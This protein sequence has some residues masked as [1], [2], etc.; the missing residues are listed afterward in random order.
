MA[1]QKRGAAVQVG[2]R[3]QRL[4]IEFGAGPA[5]EV[6]VHQGHLNAPA[7]EVHGGG[8][9]QVTVTPQDQDTHAAILVSATEG[10]RSSGKSRWLQRK[11]F[12]S[13]LLM[14]SSWEELYGWA[15]GCPVAA[16]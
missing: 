5:P 3:D 13:A 6:I 12:I 7:G 14:A 11:A 9:T 1:S 2:H 15:R 10:A 8:P 16:A 4:A